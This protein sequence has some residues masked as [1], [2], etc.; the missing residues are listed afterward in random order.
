[1]ETKEFLK[2]F[3]LKMFLFEMGISLLV[4]IV[5]CVM[6]V[7]AGSNVFG[8]IAVTLYL[9]GMYFVMIFIEAYTEGHADRSREAIN[10]VKVTHFKGLY[11]GLAA[12]AI[13]A[14]LLILNLITRNELILTVM[15][16]YNAQ[17][18]YFTVSNSPL[19][20]ALLL[21]PLPLTTWLAYWLGVRNVPFLTKIILERKR[22]I[23]TG[24]FE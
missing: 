12:S 13:P 1:M 7:L 16:F 22:K 14:F 15:R 5:G 9:N 6:F 23:K 19:I 10:L 21:L 8:L 3:L 2:K 17:Y 4:A 11:G 24:D 18:I 20:L